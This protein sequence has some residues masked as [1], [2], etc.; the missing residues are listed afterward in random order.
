MNLLI[1]TNNVGKVREYQ[2]ILREL[3]PDLRLLTLREAGIVHDV[4]ETGETFEANARLKA[5]TYAKMSGLPVIAD[6]SGLAVDAFD[7]FPG[8]VSARWAGPTDRDR[9]Q[10]L[11]QKMADIPA[12][13][14][15]AKFVCVAI[16][17][18]PDGREVLAKGEVIGYIGYQPEGEHGFGYDPLFV[19]PD[20]GQTM[21]Q[22]S[23]EEKNAISHRGRAARALAPRMMALMST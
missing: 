16:F 14:R 21:A 20:L 8:V 6:D 18:L 12:E 13:K 7:G 10:Q 4:E 15:G 19:L 9:N 2:Q 17:C 22:L 5:V 23:K 1:A 11:L 3:F